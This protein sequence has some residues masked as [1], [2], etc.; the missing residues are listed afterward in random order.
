MKTAVVSL[1]WVVIFL[2]LSIVGAFSQPASEAEAQ[3]KPPTLD[4]QW[5][6]G[7]VIDL[8][9]ETNQ[10]ILGSIN[11]DTYKDR[12][13]VIK[14]DA[15]VEYENIDSL[16]DIKAGDVISVEYIIDLEGEAVALKI[17]AQDTEPKGE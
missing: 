1:V 14:I 13:V 2:N 4:P 16:A 7:D 3:G 8:D 9:T 6:L 10:L 17:S 12:I 15:A 11:Y 5:V